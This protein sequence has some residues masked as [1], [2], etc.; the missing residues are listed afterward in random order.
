MGGNLKQ[1]AREA[2]VSLATASRV[3]S[4]S[5]YPVSAELRERVVEVAARLDYVPN[6]QA[7]AL[8]TGNARTVG[9]LVGQVGDHYFDALVD[10]VRRVAAEE[11]CLVTVVSTDRDPER[12]LASFRQLQSHGASIIIVAG[13]GLDDE[14]Y[15]VGLAARVASFSQTGRVVLLGRHE[16]DAGVPAVRV[17]ADNHG[18]G[19]ALGAHLRR[20]GHT[21]VGV[22]SGSGVVTST[23]DRVRGVAD[24]LGRAPT[25]VQV[26]QTRDGGYAGMSQLLALDADLTAVVT[27]ADQMAIGALAYCRDHGL[28]VPTDMSVAGCNDIWV[29]RDLTPSLTTVHI[30]L[31][32]MGGAALRL[33][34]AEEN[35][36]LKRQFF[37][38]QLVVRESTGPSPDA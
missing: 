27:T 24:G 6:A 5:S 16:L 21:R 38:V 18:A 12:E 34:L 9:V 14:E 26:P 28:A 25:V 1:V 32:E 10:G 33:A 3:L 19:H 2:G 13:S 20:L 23:V 35:G 17:E 22:L 36:G 11:S 31:E 37:P 15:R 8:I 29:A 7:R 30:P 4:G